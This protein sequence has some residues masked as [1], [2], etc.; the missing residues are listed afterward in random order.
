MSVL[1]IG[2]DGFSYDNSS[3]LSRETFVDL[4]QLEVLTHVRIPYQFFFTHDDYSKQLPGSLHMHLSGKVH[5]HLT[6]S[7]RSVFQC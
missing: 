4:H 6:G 2:I 1:K 7:I 3:M 5:K